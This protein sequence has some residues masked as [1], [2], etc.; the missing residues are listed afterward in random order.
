MENNF[1]K[2][3]M[4]RIYAVF[5]MQKLYGRIAMKAYALVAL[6]YLQTY[7]VS[8]HNVIEN[9]PSVTDL[10]AVLRFYSAAFVNTHFSVQVL[11]ILFAGTALWLFRDLFRGRSYRYAD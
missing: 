1:K 8:V 7:L 3:T 11:S 6:V 4:R 2:E 5:L 9:M 10:G